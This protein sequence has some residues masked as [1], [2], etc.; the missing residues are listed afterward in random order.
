MYWYYNMYYYYYILL[1]IEIVVFLCVSL[2]TAEREESGK[3]GMRTNE[4]MNERQNLRT[5]KHFFVLFCTERQ[6][7]HTTHTLHD[8]RF[9][10][11]Y[12]D[13]LLSLGRFGGRPRPA[14]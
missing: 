6:D 9:D 3:G 5:S 14:T 2:L 11:T 12:L 13:E 7:S 1:L 10:R 8:G 4:R